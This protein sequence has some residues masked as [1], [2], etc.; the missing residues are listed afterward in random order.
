MGKKS[1]L[2]DVQRAQIVALYK[3]GYSKRSISERIKQ[4]CSSQ[5][6]REI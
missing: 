5:C 1:S 6:S 2:S 4:E 3:E